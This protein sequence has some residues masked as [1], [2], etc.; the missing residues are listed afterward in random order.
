MKLNMD[1]FESKRLEM[2]KKAYKPEII[3][4]I[5]MIVLNV[6]CVCIGVYVSYYMYIRAGIIDP[7]G[8]V[9]FILGITLAVIGF[10]RTFSS[11]A[12]LIVLFKNRRSG[13]NN[14]SDY[15][16]FTKVNMVNGVGVDTKGFSVNILA[17]GIALKYKSFTECVYTVPYEHVYKVLI[18]RSL[19]SIY[20]FFMNIPADYDFSTGIVS[21]FP[22]GGV[23]LNDL[24]DG[25]DFED[26]V[27]KLKYH[28][29][30]DCFIDIDIPQE[31]LES[32][33]W[34]NMRLSIYLGETAVPD[35]Q[36]EEPSTS[37][38]A[39]SSNEESNEGVSISGDA[40]STN[41]SYSEKSPVVNNTDSD[42]CSEEGS[43]KIS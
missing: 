41:D 2:L 36:A 38:V 39:E 17:D 20:L 13:Q 34:S 42:Q 43:K 4:A 12:D 22:Y 3:H 31:K 19:G 16:G 32:F 5:W 14:I 7:L 29:N 24:F 37:E 33:I 26:V 25:F 23:I 10:E 18:D 8:L 21:G 6:V 9:T 15:M 1:K 27:S 40:E 11:L 28:I 35:E 30:G